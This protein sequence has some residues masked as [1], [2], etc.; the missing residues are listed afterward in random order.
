[1]QL[2]GSASSVGTTIDINGTDYDLAD[3]DR[4]DAGIEY[5]A[6]TPYLG[7]GWDFCFGAEKSWVL[8]IDLG[9]LYMGEPDVTLVGV[10]ALA[11]AAVED[12]INAELASIREDIEDYTFLPVVKIGFTYR[13]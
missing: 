13:F 11:D 2:D 1:M 5:N 4:L 3:G 9:V 12:D 7:L 8:G 6:V 10:G